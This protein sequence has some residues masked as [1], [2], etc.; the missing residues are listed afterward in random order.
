ML[1][2][3]KASPIES[4]ESRLNCRTGFLPTEVNERSERI[5]QRDRPLESVAPFASVPKEVAWACA[6]SGTRPDGAIL[7]NTKLGYRPPPF[8]SGCRS[9]GGNRPVEAVRFPPTGVAR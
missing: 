9:Y 7:G 6:G 4:G 1:R 3:D 2:F 8:R 5:E